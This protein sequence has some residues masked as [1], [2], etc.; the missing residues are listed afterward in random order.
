MN[1]NKEK[2]IGNMCLL[3]PYRSPK[4]MGD[5]MTWCP[6]L[7]SIDY[8]PVKSFTGHHMQGADHIIEAFRYRNEGAQFANLGSYCNAS[9][10]NVASFADAGANSVGPSDQT[11][12]GYKTFLSKFSTNAGQCPN[13]GDTVTQVYRGRPSVG[14]YKL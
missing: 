13:P 10:N 5:A 7:S 6:V 4:D 14:L 8:N 2:V 9:G 11:K 3:R 12:E 1:D